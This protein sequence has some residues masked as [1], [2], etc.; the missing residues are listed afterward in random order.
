[1]NEL[2]VWFSSE[3][4]KTVSETK[5]FWVKFKEDEKPKLDLTS[6]WSSFVLGYNNQNIL[7]ALNE[8]YK[9]NFLRGNT[10]ETSEQVAELTKIICSYG[11][12]KALTWAVSGSDAVE[13]AVAM[14][15]KYWQLVN[16]EKNKIVSFVPCYHGTTMLGKHLRGEYSSLGRTYIVNAPKWINVEEREVAES[17]C[18][19]NLNKVLEKNHK[20]IGC[21]I[22]E[23][24]PWVSDILPW[25]ENW[26]KRIRQLCF[27]YNINFLL[28]DVA[29][30]W[31]K[32][33][34]WFGYQS[35]G[36]QP[37]ICAIGK[38]LT[39]GYSPLGAAACNSKIFDVLSKESWEHGHTWQPNM[40]GV[41]AALEVTKHIEKFN[42]FRNVNVIE[43]NFRNL[44][45]KYNLN[46]RNKGL[47][48]VLDFPKEIT[49]Q[50]LY[51]VG[52]TTALFLTGEKVKHI[53]IAAPLIA[54]DEYFSMI[55]KG[56]SL[57]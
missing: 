46:I 47:I 3:K 53:K 23:T 41:I 37:D 39:G 40:H 16:P 9:V 36:I 5:S 54:N 20:H 22:F 2:K 28:D 27:A 4:E 34:T 12:W 7:E 55:D 10:G 25:S 50:N 38:A 1:M 57:L 35:Y 26:F 29:I 8:K 43:N 19:E 31:G 18:L 33:G 45:K 52:F 6:G 21:I 17:L 15:D 24:C 30:C 56:L 42:L 48:A 44:A 14:N 32:F 49:T 51:D 13:A 11:N